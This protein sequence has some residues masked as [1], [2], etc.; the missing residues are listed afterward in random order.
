MRA[1]LSGGRAAFSFLTIIP[2]GGFPYSED[3]WRWSAAWFPMVGAF[4]GLAAAGVFTVLE[5]AGFGVAAISAVAF[6]VFMTGAFHEDGLADTADALG[7]AYNRG[8][9][10]EILKD[11]RVGTYGGL[12]LVFSVALRATCLASLGLEAPI[13]LVVVHTAARTTP[14]WLMASIPYV[15]STDVSKSRPVIQGSTPQAALGTVFFVAVLGALVW[16]GSTSTAVAVSLIAT[17]AVVALVCGRYFTKRAGGITGDF[18]GATEQAN[19]VALL[20]IMTY[21][22]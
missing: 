11:S 19:E 6:T 12:A 16:Q 22:R 2:V 13:A 4:L 18:L 3:A 9:V 20:V 17:L 8:R 1:L 10:F 14:V 21:A 15:T 5:P 7:G